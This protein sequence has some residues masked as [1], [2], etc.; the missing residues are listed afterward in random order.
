MVN[1]SFSLLGFILG[2]TPE[3]V[4]PL[5]VFLAWGDARWSWVSLVPGASDVNPVVRGTVG[6]VKSR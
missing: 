5:L 1:G 4:Q 6:D 2:F 3:E